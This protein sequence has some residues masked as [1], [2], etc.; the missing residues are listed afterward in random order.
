MLTGTASS[1]GWFAELLAP[2]ETDGEDPVL[3]GSF[4]WFSLFSFSF[5]IV[6]VRPTSTRELN[7]HH[8]QIS[9]WAEGLHV[10]G[11]C[12]M[13]QRDRL[14]LCYHHLSA[15]QPEMHHTLA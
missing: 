9:I 13:P 2:A 7:S 10:M 4:W 11:C 12:P 15:M 6:L 3:Q 5:L 1:Q 8:L 14:Q